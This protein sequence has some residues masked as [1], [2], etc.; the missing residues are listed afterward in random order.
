MAVFWKITNRKPTDHKIR[1]A[2]GAVNG[3]SKMEPVVSQ[4]ENG[5]MIVDQTCS[6][7]SERQKA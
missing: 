4:L 6:T 3:K 5:E 7:A 1:I 2:M